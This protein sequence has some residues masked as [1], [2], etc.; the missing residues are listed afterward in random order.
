MVWGFRKVKCTARLRGF[1]SR[2][3]HLS[4]LKDKLRNMWNGA[5]CASV[6]LFTRTEDRA[7][8]S[9]VCVATPYGL[10]G[11]GMESRWGRDFSHPSRP[12]LGPTHPP[13]QWVPG[14]FP[15]GK[16]IGMCRWPPTP[17]SAEIKER[18]ELYLYFPS[19]PSWPVLGWNLRTELNL[20][21]E[22]WTPTNQVVPINFSI[23]WKNVMVTSCAITY[24]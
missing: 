19:A 6:H 22:I 1:I 2:L 10:D 11:L 4:W 23:W 5:S 7:R 12:A 8:D 20:S 13:T 24:R 14:F 15:G 3:R 17:S 9:S 18:V 16:A 21:A